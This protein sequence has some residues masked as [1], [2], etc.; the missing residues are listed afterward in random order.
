MGSSLGCRDRRPLQHGTIGRVS[1]QAAEADLERA[2]MEAAF[3]GDPHPGTT[4]VN[5][6]VIERPPGHYDMGSGTAPAAG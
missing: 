3:G 1:R 5:G 4:V 2:C 6:P